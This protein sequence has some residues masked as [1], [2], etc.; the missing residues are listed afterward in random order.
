MAAAF[1]MEV[2]PAQ[3]EALRSK[4]KCLVAR[5]WMAEVA[6]GRFTLAKGVS[7]QAAGHEQRHR[8]VGHRLGAG[9]APLAVACQAAGAHQVGEEALDDPPFGQHHEAACRRCA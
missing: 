3:V 9:G 1:G 8:P 6:P 5:G 4:A 2:V 7:G